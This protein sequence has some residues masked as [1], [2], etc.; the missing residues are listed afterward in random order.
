MENRAQRA[1]EQN[2]AWASPSGT[3]CL[4][5]KNKS[6]LSPHKCCPASSRSPWSAKT[7]QMGVL[8]PATPKIYN[9]PPPNPPNSE[10]TTR[11][12]FLA[13]FTYI[14]WRPQPL[15]NHPALLY[16]PALPSGTLGKST[17]IPAHPKNPITNPNHPRLHGRTL[18]FTFFWLVGKSP[19]ACM[20]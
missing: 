18:F 12:L 1:Q 16:T 20:K 9:L 19:Y 3:A 14:Y 5:G 15:P 6:N 11:P 7:S 4:I 13:L 10:R 8:Y 17:I 2:R